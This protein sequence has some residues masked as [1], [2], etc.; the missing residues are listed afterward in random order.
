VILGLVES[1]F[2]GP[3]FPVRAIL[4]DKNPDVNWTVSWHQD[5]AIPL[6]ERLE[7]PGFQGWSKKEGVWH[8]H[9]PVDVLER[10]VTARIHLD[11][12][13]PE[14]GPLCVLPGSHREGRM[15]AESI[16]E[17]KA[18]TRPHVCEVRAGE[19]LLMRPL[20]LHASESARFGGH[21]RV[22]H[23]EYGSGSLPGGLRWA[24]T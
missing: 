21:R 8:A 18:R 6:E 7:T 19:I 10:M 20:L 17:F 3:G 4:F 2:H 13:H 22:I 11:D 9:P 24:G 5:L 1:I 12:C 14:S 23:I 16:E 15:S